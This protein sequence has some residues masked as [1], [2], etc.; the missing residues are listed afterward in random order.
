M[1]CCEVD[2]AILTSECNEMLHCRRTVTKAGSDV[3]ADALPV[4]GVVIDLTGK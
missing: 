4:F 2:G 3:N 1:L